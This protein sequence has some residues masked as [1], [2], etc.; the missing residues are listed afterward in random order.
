MTGLAASGSRVFASGYGGM[1]RSLDGGVSWVP[2]NSGL[3]N[4]ILAANYTGVFAGTGDGVFRSGDEGVTWT[5]AN[6][7]LTNTNVLALA[8]DRTSVF[9]ATGAGCIARRTPV[10]AGSSPTTRSYAC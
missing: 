7:G 1:H 3:S 8:A 5:P 2:V 10:R 9:V 6:K 4:P